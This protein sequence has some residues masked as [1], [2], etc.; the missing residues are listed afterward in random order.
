MGIANNYLL[1][2]PVETDLDD[3]AL[4]RKKAEI[5][6]QITQ[7]KSSHRI[8]SRIILKKGQLRIEIA[9]P[10]ERC[11]HGRKTSE[12]CLLCN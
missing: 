12:P 1:G 9:V 8:P 3:N 6:R 11:P 4:Q 10:P 5:Q 7:I 2:L